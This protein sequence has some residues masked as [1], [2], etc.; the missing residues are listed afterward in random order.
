MIYVC[1]ILHNI[2]IER[3]EDDC[4]V[5]AEVFQYDVGQQDY[6]V[7]MDANETRREQVVTELLAQY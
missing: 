2:C 4:E 3:N 7:D 1:C 6:R 5:P